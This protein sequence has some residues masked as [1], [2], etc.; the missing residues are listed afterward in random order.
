M[1]F[2]KTPIIRSERFTKLARS[3]ARRGAAQCVPCR[4][5]SV[6][7]E[8]VAARLIAGTKRFAAEELGLVV[9]QAMAEFLE[10]RAGAPASSA[11]DEPSC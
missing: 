4:V 11:M 2:N 6:H 8:E 7:Q 9:G 5:G 3:F 1:V 10:G